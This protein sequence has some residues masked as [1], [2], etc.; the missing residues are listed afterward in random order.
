M[1]SVQV[2][3]PIP[4][5]P[6]V[7]PRRL[8]TGCLLARRYQLHDRLGGGGHAEVWSAVD[9]FE[10][11]RLALKFLR[12]S[13]CTT[14]DALLVLRHEARMAQRLQHP[15]VSRVFEPVVDDQF[16]FLPIEYCGGGDA[17]ALRG[18]AWQQVLPVLLD[19]AEIIEHAHSRGVVH[20]DIKPGNVLFD[21]NGTVRVTDFGAAA[22]MGCA[23]A[24]ATGSPFSASPQQLRGEP[25][26]T[27]DDI[28]GLGALAYELLSGYPPF[29]PHF[30]IQRAQTEEPVDLRPVHPAPAALLDLIGAM[31]SRDATRRPDIGMVIEAFAS[32]LTCQLSPRR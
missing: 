1:S 29:Y 24:F 28:H 21:V 9:L 13:D 5:L 8:Q 11:R 16:V 14:E 23:D 4:G 26:T 17:S 18:Q 32:L 15:G 3:Q 31:L 6:P 2:N 7:L 30:D 20:R 19:V 12:T 22:P 25:A 27:A 10:R